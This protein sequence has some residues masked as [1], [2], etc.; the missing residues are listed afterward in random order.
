MVYLFYLKYSITTLLSI[1]IIV[2]HRSFSDYPL[3][4]M[5]SIYILEIVLNQMRYQLTTGGT[6]IEYNK[7]QYIAL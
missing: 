5:F 1:H 7:F 2:L 4:N 6:E 3:K